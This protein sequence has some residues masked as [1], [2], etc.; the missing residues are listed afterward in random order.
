[1]PA[2]TTGTPKARALASALRRAREAH[3]IGVR[4]LARQLGIPH[5]V[6]S[7]WETGKRT[8][9]IEDIGGYLAAIGVSGAERERILDLGRNVNQHNWLT[10]GA[11]EH[12]SGVLE[13]ERTA[14]TIT[15]WSPLVVPG[16]LQTS[17]YTRSIIG[18]GDG[19][20]ET[21]PRVL[22]RA[23]RRDILTK[24]DPTRM[25]AMIGEPA[26][27]VRIGG[28][29]IHTEQLRN[30]LKLARDL[31]NLTVQVVRTALDWHPGMAGPFVL[32]DF[33]DS[34]PIVHLEHHRSSAFLYETD[35]LTAYR[36]AADTIRTE[37]A[38]SPEDSA[39]LIADVINTQ[40]TTQ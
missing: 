7:Y 22:L 24:T 33:P 15:E 1:M 28:D 25:H 11:N 29:H 19:D 23:G 20:S 35:D 21:E 13:C 31:D 26:L 4:A 6:V 3:N 38:M 14:A 34:P 37:M 18:A 36:E 2:T 39:G 30:L 40:E 8:P 27:H 9:R 32:Y 10:A 17:D 5:S 12:L 16:L